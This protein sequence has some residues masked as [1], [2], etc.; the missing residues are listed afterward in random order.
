[1]LLRGRAVKRTQHLLALLFFSVSSSPSIAACDGSTGTTELPTADPPAASVP[2]DVTPAPSKDAS[3]SECD[4]ATYIADVSRWHRAGSNAKG[5]EM[6]PD[7]S[8]AACDK[9]GAH[10][11]SLA[12]AAPDEFGTYMDTISAAPY[13]G[14]R[15]RLRGIVETSNVTGWTGLWLRV[16]DANRKMLAIDN[17]GKRAL[18]GTQAPSEQFVVLDVAS[19][20][21]EIAFGVLVSGEGEVWTSRV[22]IEIVG[23]DVPTTA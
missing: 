12:G 23:Q 18:T 14:K 9:P 22:V 8:R 4:G 2:G 11:R 20:A 1:M 6:A 16:D 5:Y 7:T 21:A 3:A 13:L 15:V 10:V 19:D 17:M